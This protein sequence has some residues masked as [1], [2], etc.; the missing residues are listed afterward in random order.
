MTWKRLDQ[1][2]GQD[3]DRRIIS[4]KSPRFFFFLVP[5]NHIL[6]DVVRP[7]FRRRTLTYEKKNQGEPGAMSTNACQ[8]PEI[9]LFVKV[10]KAHGGFEN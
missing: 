7:R 9:E 8:D 2:S 1:V 4:K 3:R 6:E 10:R 5:P